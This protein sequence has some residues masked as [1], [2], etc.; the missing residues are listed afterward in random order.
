MLSIQCYL[1]CSILHI[2]IICELI[3][4]EIKKTQMLMV[5]VEWTQ[6]GQEERT[7]VTERHEG[8]TWP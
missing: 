4:G 8:K 7:R 6:M 1:F 2:F 3:V 5:S